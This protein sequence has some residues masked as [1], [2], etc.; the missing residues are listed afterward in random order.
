[1]LFIST[2]QQ[3]N[4]V[5]NVSGQ[6]RELAKHSNCS[7]ATMSTRDLPED[8]R[9]GGTL[10][11]THGI[12]SRLPENYI[13]QFAVL[14]SFSLKQFETP[15][16]HQELSGR[17]ATLSSLHLLCFP[18]IVHLAFLNMVLQTLTLC[19]VPGVDS[20]TCHPCY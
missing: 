12:Y 7:V 20:L 10:C 4:V 1:M 3:T 5:D 2:Y 9:V 18:Y 8:P 6:L 19:I 11:A 14:A 13:Q 17:S 15:W 16:L